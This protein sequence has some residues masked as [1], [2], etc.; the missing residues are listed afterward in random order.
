MSRLV[1]AARQLIRQVHDLHPKAKITAL[2][3]V[4]GLGFQRSIRIEGEPGKRLAPALEAMKDPRIAEVVK[5]N[6]GTRVTFVTTTRAD[7]AHAFPLAE[8]LAVLED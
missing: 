3:E 6:K 5:S 7:H 4:D 1:P 2:S 8:V